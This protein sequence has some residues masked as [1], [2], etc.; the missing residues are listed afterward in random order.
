M[1]I[2]RTVMVVCSLVAAVIAV[3]TYFGP[4]DR[5]IMVPSS[6][7]TPAKVEPSVETK[8]HTNCE[9]TIYFQIMRPGEEA[10][11]IGRW[12]VASLILDYTFEFEQYGSELCVEEYDGAGRKIGIGFGTIKN[13]ALKVTI[14]TNG[15]KLD[16]SLA[17]NKRVFYGLIYL[18]GTYGEVEMH[19][20]N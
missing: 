7:S 20:Q 8:S 10:N 3:L 16:M 1:K 15:D 14:E 12:K 11:V 9:E 13:G 17:P 18:D 19:K 4:R 5:I 6:L 2:R